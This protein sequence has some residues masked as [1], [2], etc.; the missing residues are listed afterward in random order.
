MENE[1][2]VKKSSG[3]VKFLKIALIIAAI[4]FVA[5]KV[6]NKFFKKK[7]A[8]E[9]ELEGEAVEAE[10]AAIEEAEVVEEAPFEVSAEAVIDNA[11]NMEA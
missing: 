2:V 5:V 6:Y 9:A 4:T 11:E 10:V 1:I 3:F 7:A 8:A